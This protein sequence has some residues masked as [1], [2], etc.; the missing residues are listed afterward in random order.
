MA[1]PFILCLDTE[2]YAVLR[3]VTRDD[4]DPLADLDVEEDCNEL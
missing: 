1:E 4:N 3:S 2:H